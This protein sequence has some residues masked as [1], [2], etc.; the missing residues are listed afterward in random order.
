MKDYDCFEISFEGIDFDSFLP[1][2]EKVKKTHHAHLY[3]KNDEI[4]IKIYFDPKTHFDGKL[5]VWASK[6]NSRIFCSKIQT[7]N[8]EQNSDLLKIDFT[9]SSLIGISNQYEGEF[10]EIK[11]DT[12]KCY[13]KAIKEEINTADFYLNDSGFDIV[14]GFH[15]I[16]WSAEKGKFDISRMKDKGEF[17]HLDKCKFRP[18]FDFNFYDNIKN[19][20]TTITKIPKIKFLFEDDISEELVVKYANIVRLIC[21][22]YFRSEVDYTVSKI[23]LSHESIIINKI[24]NINVP[25][26]SRSLRAFNNNWNFHQL[27]Q[28]NWQKGFL[29]NHEKLSV[30]IK[31]FI[32]SLYLNFT[33][34]FL[35]LYNI[36]DIVK[37]KEINSEFRITANKK[38]RKNKCNEALNKLLEFVDIEEHEEFRKKWNSAWGILKYKPMGG[39]M[40][41]FIREHQMEPDNFPIKFNR[42]IEIRNYLVHGSSDIDYVELQKVNILLHRIDGILILHLIGIN[43]CSLNLNIK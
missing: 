3:Q 8:E 27:L 14:A 21:S 40:Q 38:E 30:V 29:E 32:Q 19:K 11:V 16:L 26:A 36:L 23:Y 31:M 18:E 13:R 39:I 28:S 5:M 7:S 20:E 15:S 43:E 33:S 42:I 35:I 9:N 24:K 37:G 6:I 10:V 17:Y 34:R 2:G 41:S 12:I 1:H 25:N 22:F 4:I